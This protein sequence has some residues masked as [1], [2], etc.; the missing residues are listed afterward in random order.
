MSLI[1]FDEYKTLP[2]GNA[3]SSTFRETPTMTPSKRTNRRGKTATLT[4]PK[5]SKTLKASPQK[6][7]SKLTPGVAYYIEDT[8]R[9]KNE[10]KEVYRGTFVKMQTIAD[11]EYAQFKEIKKLVAPFGVG[12]TPF[13]FSEKGHRFIEVK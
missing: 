4:R 8:T 10:Y 3:A 7:K 12:G 2:K 1:T 13:G 6:I 9:R 5:K 11:N